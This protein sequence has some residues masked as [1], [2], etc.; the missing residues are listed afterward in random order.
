MSTPTR[1]RRLRTWSAFGDLAYGPLDLLYVRSKSGTLV[2]LSSVTQASK[3][4][5]P[6]LVNH[7]GQIPS[8]TLSF[9]L[10]AGSSLGEAVADVGKAARESLA[11]RFLSHY[12]LDGFEKKKLSASSVPSKNGRPS[13]WAGTPSCWS[14]PSPPVSDWPCPC[15]SQ[16]STT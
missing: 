14:A 6:Q 11:R 4:I 10:R 16:V 15:G 3:S 7:T 13:D 9:N 1:P 5:G 12:G 2:P 8:V